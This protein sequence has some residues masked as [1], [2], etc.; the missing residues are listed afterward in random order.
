M[1][2]FTYTYNIQSKSGSTNACAQPMALIAHGLLG[3]VDVHWTQE[4]DDT[5]VTMRFQQP[6]HIAQ[7]AARW[8][9]LVQANWYRLSV[10]IGEGDQQRILPPVT[11]SYKCEVVL[12]GS[13]Y[14]R[15]ADRIEKA[16]KEEGIPDTFNGDYAGDAVH[17]MLGKLER[18]A[19]HIGI[20]FCEI[21]DSEDCEI[22]DDGFATRVWLSFRR[23]SDANIFLR[24][25][26]RLGWC[27]KA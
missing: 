27:T 5:G 21:E 7:F 9:S 12:S 26:H 10:D 15:E 23:R 14:R 6:E 2:N 22:G 18:L 24:E 3:E 11:E 20:N 25:V 13:F 17:G 16:C 8:S 1:S 4:I 19:S